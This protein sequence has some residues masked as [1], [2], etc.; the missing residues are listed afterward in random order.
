MSKTGVSC[1]YQHDMVPVVPDLWLCECSSYGKLASR[2]DLAAEMRALIEK[3]GGFKV[4]RARLAREE[5][6][7][8]KKRKEERVVVPPRRPVQ[9]A[10]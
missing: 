2:I 3:Q 6:A 9:D 10:R 5:E 4:Y 8:Q 1:A 7:R